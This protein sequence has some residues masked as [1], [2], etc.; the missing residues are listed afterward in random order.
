MLNLMKKD[1]VRGPRAGPTG[2]AERVPGFAQ[3][4]NQMRAEKNVRAESIEDLDRAGTDRT[5]G[6][7]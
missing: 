7:L 6:R 4:G 1:Q 2:L 5:S 3:D